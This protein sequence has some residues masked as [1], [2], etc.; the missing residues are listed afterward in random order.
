VQFATKTSLRIDIQR[1]T[2]ETN[3]TNN[4]AQYPVIFS[5]G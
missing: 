4:R 5:L 2:G 3:V 1:V